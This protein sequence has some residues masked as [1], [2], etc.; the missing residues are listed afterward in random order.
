VEVKSDSFKGFLN[1]WKFAVTE[2]SKKKISTE[3]KKDVIELENLTVGT[4]I[5]S[6]SISQFWALLGTF[7]TISSGIA[8]AAYKLGGG[9]WPWE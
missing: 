2:T 9:K 4:L 1:S 8:M 6:L 7:A 3:L 5:K